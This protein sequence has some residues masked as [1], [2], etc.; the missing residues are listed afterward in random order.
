MID[1]NKQLVVKLKKS[2]NKSGKRRRTRKLLGVR[3]T[4]DEGKG[5]SF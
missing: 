3:Y 1:A 4:C 5:E 2:P